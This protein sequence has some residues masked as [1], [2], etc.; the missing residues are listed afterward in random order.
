MS[1]DFSL[2]SCASKFSSSKIGK[3]PQRIQSKDTVFLRFYRC[4][5]SSIRPPFFN[6]GVFTNRKVWS[7]A[8]WAV[9]CAGSWWKGCGSGEGTQPVVEC[10]PTPWR[11]SQLKSRSPVT[12][13]PRNAPLG[14]NE[15]SY[16]DQIR[17]QNQATMIFTEKYIVVD[18]YETNSLFFNNVAP[19]VIL[20]Y[21]PRGVIW[22]WILT[23]NSPN[24][25]K[26][27]LAWE[28]FEGFSPSNYAILSA[29]KC[30]NY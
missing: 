15:T 8:L 18:W 21:V 2:E 3:V 22:K 23:H 14:S 16:W 9:R 30:L 19:R 7:C 6:F 26:W 29:G 10:S 1:L 12:V 25:L 20:L 5:S 24:Y 27:Y 11:P 17:L 28:K 4:P 13:A